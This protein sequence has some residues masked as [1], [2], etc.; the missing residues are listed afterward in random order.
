MSQHES[1][2]IFSLGCFGVTKSIPACS[3]LIPEGGGYFAD[4]RVS[5]QRAQ[6]ATPQTGRLSRH[7]RGAVGSFALLAQP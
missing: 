3:P 1:V 6:Q 5:H 7:S 4:E 2:S